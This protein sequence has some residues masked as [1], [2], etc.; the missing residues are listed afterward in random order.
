MKGKTSI[1]T[2]GSGGLGYAAAEAL[3]ELGGDIAL[4]YNSTPCEDKAESLAKRFGVKAK[5]YKCPVD[6]FE[7][8]EKLVHKVKE[9]FGRVDVYARFPLWF[10]LP[11]L[12]LPPF[13]M[14]SLSPF[15]RLSA[16]PASFPFLHFLTFFPCLP[17]FSFL[18]LH[19]QRRYG[20]KRSHQRA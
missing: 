4:V 7:E 12:P 16:P 18:Q 8:V 1:I 13:F 2:G 17:P 11:P 14:S 20:R 10:P 3:A 6:D 15:F 19:R 5:A 9:E